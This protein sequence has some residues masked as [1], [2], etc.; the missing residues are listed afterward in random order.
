MIEIIITHGSVKAIEMWLSFSYLTQSIR[1]VCV[2]FLFV[3]I[4]Y[5]KLWKVGSE[6]FAEN[7]YTPKILLFL[8]LLFTAFLSL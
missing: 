6:V 7:I 3:F 5:G 8:F 4:F 2:R 1:Y